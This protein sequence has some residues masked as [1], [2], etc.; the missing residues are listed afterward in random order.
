MVESGNGGW[1]GVRREDGAEEEEKE[2]RREDFVS[3]EV[4]GEGR[5]R[6]S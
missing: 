1:C 3:H 2:I 5:G 6:G 4:R